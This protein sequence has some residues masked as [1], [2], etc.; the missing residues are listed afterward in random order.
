M[1]IKFDKNNRYGERTFRETAWKVLV[2][3]IILS[4]ALLVAGHFGVFI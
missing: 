2:G 4:V 1:K 3:I